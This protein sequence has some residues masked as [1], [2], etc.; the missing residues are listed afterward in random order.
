MDNKIEYRTFNISMP[1]PLI[2]I[3]DFLQKELNSILSDNTCRNKLNK[4][5]LTKHRGNI[6]RNMRDIFK[7]R[8][9]SWSINNKTWY[10][11]ILYENLRREL[12]SKEENVIVWDEYTLNNKRIDST[13]FANLI[14]K[15]KIYATRGR[16]NSIVSAGVKPELAKEAVFQLD[17]TISE[18]QMFRVNK[19][20][21]CLFEIKVGPSSK[22]WIGYYIQI[23]DTARETLTGKIAKSRFMK[24]KSDG[25]YIGICSY[26]VE[27]KE[28]KKT[29]RVLGIDIGKVNPYSG[30][31]I[32]DGFIVSSQLLPSNKLYNLTNKLNVLK[33]EKDLLYE[34]NKRFEK[35]NIETLK[36]LRREE[37]YKNIRHKISNLTTYIANQIAFEVVALAE[38][39]RCSE[40]HVENLFWLKS[41]AGK[42]NHS[43]ILKKI[44]KVARLK[45]IKLV[46]VNAHNSS[47]EHPITGEVGKASNRDIVFL[48]SKYIDRDLLGAINLALRN[49]NKKQKRK[50][51]ELKIPQKAKQDLVNTKTKKK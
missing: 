20:C 2:P 27:I 32:E 34:K 26:E 43:E 29:N 39:H 25:K 17:Y 11:Y 37:H 6:W 22:D 19:Y 45:G 46:K 13:L 4:I 18:K 40:I 48:N 30:I 42:W 36:N 28:N 47:K 14:S 38:E 35:Y 24:R 15:H 49:K 41:T 21:T 9:E 23:P 51:K 50:L 44:E 3:Y 12:Q 16:V 31:V 7:V 10:S 33:K 1:E 5:D 8:L